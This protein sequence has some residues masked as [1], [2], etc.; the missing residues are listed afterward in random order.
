LAQFISS[1]HLTPSAY[2]HAKVNPRPRGDRASYGE[3][4]APEGSVLPLSKLLKRKKSERRVKKFTRLMPAVR[5]RDPT[6]YY[7]ALFATGNFV[8]AIS[9]VE[10]AFAGLRRH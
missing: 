5:A 8:C 6:R 9:N 7:A 1:A 10:T 2:R 3:I 4:A